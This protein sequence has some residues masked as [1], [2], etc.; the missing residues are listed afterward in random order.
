M[1]CHCLI[2]LCH[3]LEGSK[4][5][6]PWDPGDK[7]QGAAL[8]VRER[9][10]RDGGLGHSGAEVLVECPDGDAQKAGEKMRV[11]VW[12]VPLIQIREAADEC[13]EGHEIMEK[14]GGQKVNREENGDQTLGSGNLT[15][16]QERVSN[17][18]QSRSGRC[19]WPVEIS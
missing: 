16:M 7:E 8:I 10:G 3:V 6:I 14:V 15:T 5:E 9:S 1:R 17:E 11:Q 4:R 13:V 2:F 19:V 12:W 18:G